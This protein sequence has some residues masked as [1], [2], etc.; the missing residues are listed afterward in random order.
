[1]NLKYV[2]PVHKDA[3]KRRTMDPEKWITGPDPL[4]RDKRYAWLKHRAQCKHRKEDY[5]LTW[6]EW[7]SLWTDELFLK[8]GRANQDLCLMKVELDGDWSYGNVKIVTRGEQLKRNREYRRDR[9][10]I[11]SV[12][13]VG[14]GL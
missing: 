7:E 13:C 14:A 8:R 3:K 9:Q 5:N 6:E 2:P 1:M 10:W 4:R 11:W 12:W